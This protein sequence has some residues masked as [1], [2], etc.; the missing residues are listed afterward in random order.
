LN[1]RKND[2]SI[3]TSYIF[4]VGNNFVIREVSL[5]LFRRSLHRVEAKRALSSINVQASISK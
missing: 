2:F 3:Y 4:A 1:D 5:M